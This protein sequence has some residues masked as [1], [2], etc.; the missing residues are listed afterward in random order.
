[1]KVVL[2]EYHFAQALSAIDLL[3][4]SNLV[5]Y[6]GTSEKV[7][8]QLSQLFVFVIMILIISAWLGWWHFHLPHSLAKRLNQ[9]RTLWLRQCPW[10]AAEPYVH[11][12]ESQVCTAQ[13][14]V[15]HIRKS[16]FIFQMIIFFGIV[17]VFQRKHGEARV[18][19]HVRP[20]PEPRQPWPRRE[21]L[22]PRVDDTRIHGFR[23]V[24]AWARV[25]H[26]GAG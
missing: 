20:A 18:V 9:S 17:L 15:R 22:C 26:R 5:N 11:P 25:R 7:C 2:V 19:Q 14:K 21:E 13:S 3:D 24:G 4:A 12:Q 6:F 1:M 10:R 16:Y 8:G 23:R